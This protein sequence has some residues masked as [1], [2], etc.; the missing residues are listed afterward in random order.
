ML[1][2]AH[3]GGW[4]SVYICNTKE[5]L[6]H[7]Y[8]QS[9]LLTMIAQEFM[10][11]DQYVRCLCLGQNEVLPMPYNPNE[12]KYIADPNYLSPPLIQRMVDDS[13]KLVASRSATT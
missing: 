12:K 11:W 6:I 7:N 5:E 4:Q 3:G 2:D 1:K 9:G 8:D 10:K 13:L